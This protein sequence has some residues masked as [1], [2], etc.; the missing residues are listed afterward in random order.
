MI[1]GNVVIKLL[2]YVR[3]AIN[4]GKT[5]ARPIYFS[6]ILRPMIVVRI[7]NLELPRIPLLIVK[8]NVIDVQSPA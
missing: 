6:H 2:V 5:L 8:L 1:L 4:G 7:V 3:P